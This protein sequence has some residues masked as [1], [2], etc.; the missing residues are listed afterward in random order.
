M[1]FNLKVVHKVYIGF[2]VI[3]GLLVGSSVLSGQKLNGISE[4]TGQVN[5]IAVPILKQSN[6]LQINLLK[7]AKLSTLSFNLN[8]VEAIQSSLGQFRQATAKFDNN[9][10]QLAKLVSAEP[11]AKKTLSEAQKNYKK[12]NQAVENMLGAVKGRI[13][14]T[15]TLHQTHEAL[16]IAIDAASSLLLELTEIDKGDAGI[17]DTMEGT[18]NQLEGYLFKFFSTGE[19]VIQL[20]DQVKL[21][22]SKSDVGF[23]ISDL[24]GQFKY[25]GSLAEQVEASGVMKLFLVEFGQL[26]A[27]LMGENNLLEIKS[28]Q[29]N[30]IALA[31]EQL[32]IAE[33]NANLATGHLDS[34][35][36]QTDKQFNTLQQQ[37]LTN[38]EESL[39]QQTITMITLIVIAIFAAVGTSRAMLRP[40]RGINQV[41]KYMAQGDL[42]RKLTVKSD[43]EFG[44]LSKNINDVV[45][46]L[47]S[48]VQQIVEGST[49]LTSNLTIVAENSSKDIREMSG[50]VEQ[51]RHIVDEVNQITESMNESTNLVAQK[52]DIAVEEMVK[53]QQT[54]QRVDDIAQTNNQRIGELAKKLDQTTVNIDQLQDDS[55]MIGGIVEAIRSIADQTNLLALNAAIEAARAGEQG[56]G[57]AVVADEVR[58]LAVRTSSA[59]TEIKTMIEKLQSQIDEAVSDISI[60]K[61]QVTECVKYTDELTQSLAMINGA[62][63]QIH[64]MNAEIADSSK[65]QRDQSHQIKEKVSV[66][67]EI[68]EKNAGKS[69]SMLENSNQIAALADELDQSVHTFKV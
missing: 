60:G 12:Y 65:E 48:L 4:S 61:Q 17:L 43:D 33:T 26:S 3:V 37:V 53:A 34:L 69:Q 41:L 57:F 23:M 55:S 6:Q 66:V 64:G 18:A 50:F 2:G 49:K 68:A 54:S 63:I 39:N 59:T 20:T 15:T 38:V 21:E 67:L 7:Q 10:Q 42:S 36:Q 44:Q 27:L 8:T 1:S 25:L 24:N 47:T 52:A 5:D 56:R 31:S 46:D 22:T 13:E 16:K 32:A 11:A 58:S 9:Y 40:L 14:A 62:I 35:L 28:S 19:Q 51:Q 30:Q 45:A 29:L